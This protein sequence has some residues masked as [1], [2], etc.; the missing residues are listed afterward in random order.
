MECGNLGQVFGSNIQSDR[1]G[2]GGG[3]TYRGGREVQIPWKTDGPIR[4]RL[5]ISPAKHQEGKA[6]VGAS[7]EVT[8]VGGGGAGSLRKF[9]PCGSSCGTIIWSGDMGAYRDNDVAVRGSACEFPTASH[10]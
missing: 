5:D 6:G 9:L 7:Q 4:Q 8:L 1:G 3:G 10:T 2:G